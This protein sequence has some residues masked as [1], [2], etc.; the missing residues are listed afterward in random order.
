L[1]SEAFD[2]FPIIFASKFKRTSS[3]C[4]SDWLACFVTTWPPAATATASV[5]RASTKVDTARRW[6]RQHRSSSN[7]KRRQRRPI[8]RQRSTIDAFLTNPKPNLSQR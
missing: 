3:P 4:S 2:S 5:Q 8:R 7:N 6:R 1:S